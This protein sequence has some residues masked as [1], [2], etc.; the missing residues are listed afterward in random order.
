MNKTLKVLL[1]I[2]LVLILAAVG[3]FIIYYFHLDQKFLDWA[4]KKL[5]AMLEFK[6]ADRA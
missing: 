5:N 4:R 2:L 1:V 6:K 3:L